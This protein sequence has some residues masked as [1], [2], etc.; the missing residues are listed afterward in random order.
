M[1]TLT[2]ERV[3]KLSRGLG[4]SVENQIPLAAKETVLGIGDVARDLTRPSI[5]RVRGDAGDVRGSGGDVDEEQQVIRDQGP[6][7]PRN[8]ESLGRCRVPPDAPD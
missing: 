3:T 7:P 1:D 6:G 4:I 2:V 8:V 5:V